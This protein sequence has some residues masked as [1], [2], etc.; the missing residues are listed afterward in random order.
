MH[1]ETQ[2]SVVAPG[3][4]RSAAKPCSPDPANWDRRTNAHPTSHV[5]HPRP[6]RA[7]SDREVG[8]LV[9][10][11]IQQA[12]QGMKW[13]VC[14]FEQISRSHC[15]GL[16]N[17]S[18]NRRFMGSQRQARGISRGLVRFIENRCQCGTGLARVPGTSAVGGASW[19]CRGAG[20]DP[21]AGL[22]LS[23]LASSP[24]PLPWW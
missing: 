3:D 21:V 13:R 6:W 1:L 15:K 19:R 9:P 16:W 4:G 14:R 23:R 18:T 5:P 22:N 8:C 7:I 10:G 20:V 11:T 2:G 24:S 17:N 12:P